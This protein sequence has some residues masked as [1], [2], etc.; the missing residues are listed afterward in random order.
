[1]TREKYL[2][3]KKMWASQG[4]K[5]FDLVPNE[6]LKENDMVEEI[7]TE[8]QLDPTMFYQG[9]NGK[10]NMFGNSIILK[11]A[12]ATIIADAAG[13]EL[14]S[15]PIFEKTKSVIQVRNCSFPVVSDVSGKIVFKRMSNIG[16]YQHYGYCTSR[17]VE[18]LVMEELCNDD[19][20][21]SEKKKY[22]NPSTMEFE[23]FR[24]RV[25]A[26]KHA[27]QI[28]D[29]KLRKS[30]MKVIGCPDFVLGDENAVLFIVKYTFNRSNPRVQQMLLTGSVGNEVL[31]LPS[32]RYEKVESTTDDTIYT[33]KTE[34]FNEYLTEDVVEEYSEPIIETKIEEVKSEVVGRTI[35]D[36]LL[37]WIESGVENDV[38]INDYAKW[39]FNFSKKETAVKTLIDYYK[40][41]SK[42]GKG[43]ISLIALSTLEIENPKTEEEVNRLIN[44]RDRDGII[45]LIKSIYDTPIF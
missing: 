25:S 41:K 11:P 29:T 31:S 1:M 44:T 8:V 39:V 38:V 10:L 3:R 9:Y 37:D 4:R 40:A 2:E 15:P 27:Q 24:F 18:L 35:Y 30:G 19:K 23:L 21:P 17:D 12:C 45:E 7:I 14:A 5:I 43:Q 26:Q 36:D 6:P 16:T 13:V 22:A 28:V 34:S 33:D 42:S 20:R 32:A